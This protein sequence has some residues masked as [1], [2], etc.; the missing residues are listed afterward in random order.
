MLADE[1][2]RGAGRAP[3]PGVFAISV[4]DMRVGIVRNM[5]NHYESDDKP[6]DPAC[7]PCRH[8]PAAADPMWTATDTP[9][10]AC[11][12]RCRC[13]QRPLPVMP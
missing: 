8:R 12:L 13:L 7:P 1:L 3:P 4:R 9:A 11:P 10:A 6:N 5:Y 2:G